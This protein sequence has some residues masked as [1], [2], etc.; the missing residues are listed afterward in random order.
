MIDYFSSKVT[1]LTKDYCETYTTPE[2]CSINK[3]LIGGKKLNV[4][5]KLINKRHITS[6]VKM[7]AIDE[8]KTI[9]NQ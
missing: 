1:T 3:R 5:E 8:I 9:E 4:I 2:K 6:S 7:M